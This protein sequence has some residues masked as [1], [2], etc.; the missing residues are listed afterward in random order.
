MIARLFG[1]RLTPTLTVFQLY[2]GELL[3][4]LNLKAIEFNIKN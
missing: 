4:R 1:L 2:S 3:M